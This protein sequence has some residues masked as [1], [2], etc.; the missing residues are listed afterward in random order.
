MKK[1]VLVS[2]LACAM[3]FL[4]MGYAY[5]T[6]SLQV[7]TNVATGELDVKFVDL[8]LFGVYGDEN[9]P[10][11]AI[12]DGIDPVLG[13]YFIMDADRWDDKDNYNILADPGALEEYAARIAGY[14]ETKFDAKLVDRA[15]LG[16]KIGDYVKTTKASDKIEIDITNIYPGYAQLFRADIVNPGTLAA[17]LS[18]VFVNTVSDSNNDVYDMVGV[19]LKVL[20]E[21]GAKVV[22]LLDGADNTFEVGGAKFVRLSALTEEYTNIQNNLLSIYP[23]NAESTI[24]RPYSMDL[25]IGVAMDPDAE[26]V[27]TTGSVDFGNING[28]DDAVTQNGNA[29]FTVKFGWDQ[30]NT[31]TNV[32]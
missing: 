26:G 22:N 8:G 1:K 18:K 10:T 2:V 14:T 16:K 17:K 12:Y 21:N 11:W 20:R 23:A 7:D 3:L 4:G 15:N 24:D 32:Q 13:G 30:F 29:S 31:P 5:W 6:D 9:N 27:W 25:I 19:S 28:N